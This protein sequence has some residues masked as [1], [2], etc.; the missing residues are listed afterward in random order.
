MT[1]ISCGYFYIFGAKFMLIH[2]LF[3]KFKQ[4]FVFL[5]AGKKC[6]V[7]DIIFHTKTYQMGQEVVLT[8]LEFDK[9]MCILIIRN[10]N[11][12]RFWTLICKINL[13]HL[14]ISYPKISF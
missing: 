1:H 10:Y 9:Q 7:Y 13:W 11:L 8:K 3:A 4:E 12:V 2:W 14:D 5:V 6:K